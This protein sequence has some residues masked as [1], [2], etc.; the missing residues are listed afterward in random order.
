MLNISFSTKLKFDVLQ[1]KTQ[2]Y[3]EL[4][5]NIGNCVLPT[6]GFIVPIQEICSL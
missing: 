5:T 1:Y 3:V 2:E 6:S 4:K